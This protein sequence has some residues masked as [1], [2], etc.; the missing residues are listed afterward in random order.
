LSIKNRRLIKI[1]EPKPDGRFKGPLGR[2]DYICA[3]IDAWMVIGN[4]LV[5]RGFKSLEADASCLVFASGVSNSSTTDPAEF[6][7]EKRLL[8]RVMQEHREKTLLY[9]STCSVYDP[10]SSHSSYVRHKLSMESYI[11]AH[12][13]AYHLFRISNL[14]GFSA[15]P[16]TFLNF[17]ALRIRTGAP[18]QVWNRAERNLIDLDDAVKLSLHIFHQRLFCNAVVNV[19]NPANEPVP[20][21]VSV[22]ESVL[23]RKG[24]YQLVDRGSSPIIDTGPIRPLT[25]ELQISFG[26]QYLERVVSKYFMHG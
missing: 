12:H 10:Y 18:F 2:I 4:G 5:A 3:S 8:E 13:P 23:G 15:N 26:Q 22:L 11:A 17:F 21:I 9:F 24:N 19:A 16:H 14:A 20:R 7:R 25:E 1:A 6:D